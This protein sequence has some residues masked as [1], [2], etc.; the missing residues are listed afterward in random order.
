[1]TAP[2]EPPAAEQPGSPCDPAGAPPLSIVVPVYNEGANIGRFLAGLRDH[3]RTPNEILIVYDFDEDDTLPAMRA[4]DR[5]PATLRLVKNTLG[6]GVVNA[7]RV[8]LREARGRAVVVSMADCSDDPRHVDPMAA[9]VLDGADIVAGSRYMPGGRQLG[10]PR[11]KRFLSRLAGVT[12]YRLT[13]IP[14]RDLTTNFRGYSRR[15]AREIEIESTGGFEV[16]LELTVKAHLR[17]WRLDEIPT[18]WTDRTAGKSRFRLF[19]WLGR[20]LRWYTLLFGAEYL[21]FLFRRH[22]PATARQ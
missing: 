5:P 16:A 15:V 2:A 10:G 6:R 19:G 7:L 18:T 11:L 22:R 4:M 13:S 14:I 20:Y 3:V 21:P 1:M 8:G 12:A 9:R 17:G